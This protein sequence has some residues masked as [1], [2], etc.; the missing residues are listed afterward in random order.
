MLWAQLCDSNI[1]SLACLVIGQKCSTYTKYS[2]NSIVTFITLLLVPTYKSKSQCDVVARKATSYPKSTLV[3]FLQWNYYWRYKMRWW[4]VYRMQLL[5]HEITTL[6]RSL[7][8]SYNGYLRITDRSSAN[9]GYGPRRKSY[10]HI[11]EDYTS[12]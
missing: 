9:S 6:L 5:V 11:N 4:K 2:Q 3:K 8:S 1:L 7:P 10:K 12:Q